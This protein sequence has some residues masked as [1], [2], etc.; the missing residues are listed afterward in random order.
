MTTILDDLSRREVRCNIGI[1]L[2]RL[3][4]DSGSH[5][6][7]ITAIST[8]FHVCKWQTLLDLD[9]FDVGVVVARAAVCETS[10]SRARLA[11]A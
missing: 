6:C 5:H 2:R 4:I 8:L 7:P 10:S 9:G 1:D 11:R 3:F